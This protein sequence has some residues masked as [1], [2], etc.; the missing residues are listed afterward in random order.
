MV[1][2]V[3]DAVKD[4][5]SEL[6]FLRVAIEKDLINYSALAR[7]IQPVV[8]EKLG[9]TP[10]IDA[11]I[12]AIR[13]NCDAIKSQKNVSVVDVIG[14][15]KVILRT[16]MAMVSLSNWIDSKVMDK[17]RQIM[18]SVDFKAGEKFYILGRTDDIMIICNSRLV[19]EVTTNLPEPSKVLLT[20]LNLS[21]ITIKLK[22]G[23]FDVPGI[24]DFYTDQ[25]KQ[26]GVNIVEIFSSRGKI[27]F[28]MQQKDAAKVYENIVRGIEAIKI[29]NHNTT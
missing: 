20:H 7:Y 28:L 12:V 6:T 21:I 4:V 16:D 25:F 10:S 24:L 13:R 18:F 19:P 15:S 29:T 9:V 3:S 27:S 8:S 23:A 14:T 17:L 5:I 22:T 2:S 1:Y 11:I 26:A